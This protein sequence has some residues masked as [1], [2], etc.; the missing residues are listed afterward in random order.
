MKDFFKVWYARHVAR[1]S[2]TK[3]II[4]KAKVTPVE[5]VVFR[6][7]MLTNDVQKIANKLNVKKD[8]T[9]DNWATMIQVTYTLN[10]QGNVTYGQP[11]V[12]TK[13]PFVF[14]M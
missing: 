9:L 1:I 12:P 2:M 6:F 10:K 5:R 8:I 7:F 3:T 11:Y 14:I 13:Q 4:H